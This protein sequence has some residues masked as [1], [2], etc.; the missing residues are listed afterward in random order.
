MEME[1]VDGSGALKIKKAADLEVAA[2]I[3]FKILFIY[4]RAVVECS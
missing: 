4:R 3:F 1:A 2:F